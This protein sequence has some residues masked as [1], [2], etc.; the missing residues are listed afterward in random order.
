MKAFISL[1]VVLIGLTGCGKTQVQQEIE[2]KQQIEESKRQ[3]KES[4]NLMIKSFSIDRQLAL[5]YL[6]LSKRHG[7]SAQEKERMREIA[8]AL[9]E[10]RPRLGINLSDLTKN[11]DV[12]RSIAEGA[13]AQ[14]KTLQEE[15]AKDE[16]K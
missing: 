16:L 8:V 15:Q 9:N 5:E 2:I 12:M 14:L 7:K 3:I 4:N 10:G 1:L 11:D 13:A 6:E